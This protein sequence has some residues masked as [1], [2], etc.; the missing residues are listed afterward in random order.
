MANGQAS[1]CNLSIKGTSTTAL[2]LTQP[3]LIAHLH[4]LTEKPRHSPLNP[5][6]ATE[7]SIISNHPDCYNVSQ[8][9]V[10]PGRTHKKQRING[11]RNGSPWEHHN[12]TF[13]ADLFADGGTYLLYHGC[14]DEEF[15]LPHAHSFSSQAHHASNS[16]LIES[17]NRLVHEPSPDNLPGWQRRL[18]SHCTFFSKPLDSN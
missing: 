18:L 3:L 10:S 4:R 12:E 7:L 9:A 11:C 17:M 14:G 16:I 2:L 15:P 1:Q 6:A 8:V 5:H 13:Q